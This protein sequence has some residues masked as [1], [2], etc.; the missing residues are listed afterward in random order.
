MVIDVHVS[1]AHDTDNL[2]EDCDQLIA[3]AKVER[4]SK[5]SG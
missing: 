1:C 5:A 4:E 3:K 2:C